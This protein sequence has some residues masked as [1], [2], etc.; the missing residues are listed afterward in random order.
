MTKNFFDNI[1]ANGN[2]TSIVKRERRSWNKLWSIQLCREIFLERPYQHRPGSKESGAA[3]GNVTNELAK[4]D[5][6]CFATK[7]I[8]DHHNGLQATRRAEVAEEKRLSGVNIE[9][10]ELQIALDELFDDT[11]KEKELSVGRDEEKKKNEDNE[12]AKA[13]EVR[14]IAMETHGQSKKRESEQGE[15]ADIKSPSLKRRTGTE[16]LRFL[17]EK[18]EL[19]KKEHEDTMKLKKERISVAPV[20]SGQHEKHYGSID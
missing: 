12:K 5:G 8:R 20:G 13:E 14:K 9:L 3:W 4:M 11:Q 19:M 10:N 15:D 6:F 16:T 2:D 1:A 18:N 17:M 7:A